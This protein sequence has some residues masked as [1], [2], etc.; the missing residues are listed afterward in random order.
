M[1]GGLDDEDDL[2]AIYNHTVVL[3]LMGYVWAYW[4]R[5]VLIIAA[6]L[7]YTST[8]VA[9]PWIVKWT[10]DSYIQTKDLSGIYLV[11]LVFMGVAVL[12]FASQYTQ[13]RVMGF[14]GQRVLYTLRVEL[15]GHL[16]RL[17][18]KFFDRN[19][20]GKVMSRIQ[21]D[22]EELEDFVSVAGGS[23]VRMPESWAKK[24][25]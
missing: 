12:Q 13:I 16:Q 8:V 19:E 24:A 2:G 14:V 20:V 3:R 7:V 9:L 18:M 17:S 15:F 21:N 22:T 23:R 6:M 10:I 4:R 5:L 1:M 25:K 11:V